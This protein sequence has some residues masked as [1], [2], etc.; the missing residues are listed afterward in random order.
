MP[1]EAG[2]ERALDRAAP[3]LVALFSGIAAVGLDHVWQGLTQRTPLLLP[4]AAVVVSVWY[5]GLGPGV[6]TLTVTTAGAAFFFMSPKGAFAVTQPQDAA[7]LV[8]YA[9]VAGFVAN[10]TARLRRAREIALTTRARFA[11]LVGG[12]QSGLVWEAEARTMRFTFVSAHADRVSG[13]TAGEWLGQDR[14]FVGHVHPDDRDDVKA[15]IGAALSDGAEHACDHRFVTKQGAVLWLNTRVRRAIENGGAVLRG[16]SVDV[17]PMK[18]TEAARLAAERARLEVEERFRWLIDRLEE[19]AIFMLD[20]AGL[21]MSWNAGAERALGYS[22][23]DVL[24]QD[25]ARFYPPDDVARGKPAQDLAAAEASGTFEDEGAR[26]RRDGRSFWA[27][28]T[29]TALHDEAGRLRGFAEV[30]RDVSARR[31]AEE[32]R[33]FLV[34]ATKELTASLDYDETLAH[35]A[36]LAVPHVADWCTIDL[37]EPDGSLRRVGSSHVDAEKAALVRT[38]DERFPYEAI[39][40]GIRR[41]LDTG[42]VE[43]YTDVTEPRLLE[44]GLS[45]EHAAA[46]TELG[47]RSIIIVPLTG[48]ESTLGTI[49]LVTGTSERTY[50]TGDVQLARD[51]GQRAGMAV[52]NARLYRDARQAIAVRDEFLSIA[53]HELRTPLTALQLQLQSVV[54]GAQRTPDARVPQERMLRAVDTATRQTERLAKLVDSLLDVSRITAGRLELEREP[55][56]L[57]QV[58]RDAVAR[59][60]SELRAA[61]C[62]VEIRADSGVVGSWDRMRVEQIVTNL[63]ANAA[64]YGA[65]HPVE[66]EVEGDTR[67]ARLRVRDHGIGIAKEA[68]P[69]IFERFERAVSSRTFGGLG[70]GLY[71]VRQIVEAHGGTIRATSDPEEGTTFEVE[72]PR[73]VEARASTR[74]AAA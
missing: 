38:L 10:L 68:L 32:A 4:L 55:L 69:R 26:R 66:I 67:T 50:D 48:R 70:L 14:F 72:L 11:D 13:Y 3:Y 47:L 31:R 71:I 12:I 22:V 42:A 57:A 19:H 35:I 24:G 21:V 52:E 63:L 64:K 8:V 61:G 73:A 2:P 54:R 28:V 25:N 33:R 34:E 65:G 49:T 30:M 6:V 60:S 17:T 45:P 39:P 41:V 9:F 15:M 1:S 29:I 53:S 16:L 43:Y 44:A 59:L 62:S 20:A 27:E 37:L 7:H 56:D 51:L 40:L 46:L 5:G 23:D 58:A 36:D 74:G 18:E